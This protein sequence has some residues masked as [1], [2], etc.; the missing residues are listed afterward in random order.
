M[1]TRKL[2]LWFA[3]QS[4]VVQLQVMEN[5][6]ASRRI[7][8]DDCRKK[9][10]ISESSAQKEFEYLLQGIK[11][12]NRE[13]NNRKLSNRDDLKR[14]DENRLAAAKAKAERAA[15]KKDNLLSKLRPIV[16]QLRSEGISWAIISDYI[17]E[18]HKKRVSRGYLHKVFSNIDE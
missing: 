10:Q 3:K 9:K 7:Y 11:Q 13:A 16:E 18:H 12:G 8:L 2:L 1:D 14:V 6:L 4:D 15:P 17:A 5:V